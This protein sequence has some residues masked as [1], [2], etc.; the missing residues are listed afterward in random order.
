[1]PVTGFV[2]TIPSTTS[3]KNVYAMTPAGTIATGQLTMPAGAVVGQIV[4]ISS[5]QRIT[6]LT[7]LANT[8][9]TLLDP[10][11]NPFLAGSF[12]EYVMD[13]ASTWHRIG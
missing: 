2:A 10:P 11:A 9:Q 12:A 8:G 1:M 7:L 5:H 13:G 3:N 4:N 6:T